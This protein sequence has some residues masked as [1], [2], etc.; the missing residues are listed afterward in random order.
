MALKTVLDTRFYFSYYNPEDEKVAAWSKG[1]IQKISI[2]EL[3]A[4]SSTL[5]IVELYATM[6]GSSAWTR[7]Q[8]GSRPQSFGR[9]VHPYNRGDSPARRKISLSMPRMPLADA[10]IG[11]TALTHAGGVVITNDEHFTNVKAL[12]RVV[13]G[14]LNNP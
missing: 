14:G 13:K 3:K 1:L 4:A 11:A 10:I 5:T 6:R 8:L 7:W 12:R 9:S 2:G